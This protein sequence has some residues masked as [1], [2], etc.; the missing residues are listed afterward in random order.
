MVESASIGLVGVRQV[1]AA[2]TP[3]AEPPQ[4]IDYSTHRCE[5]GRWMM[6]S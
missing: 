1:V 4:F 5:A 6:G 3:V 2:A